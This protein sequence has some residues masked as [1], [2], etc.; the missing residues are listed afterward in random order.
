MNRDIGIYRFNAFPL[1]FRA[2]LVKLKSFPSPSINYSEYIFPSA[3]QSIN[4]SNSY[5]A[6]GY[7]SCSNA[8]ILYENQDER[9]SLP[10]F[11]LILARV[12]CVFEGHFILL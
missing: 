1:M 6:K 8:D 10:S 5:V 7:R 11:S 12:Y 4:T 2:C 9:T 3:L